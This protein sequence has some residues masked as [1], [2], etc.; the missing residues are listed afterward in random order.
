MTQETVKCVYRLVKIKMVI[1]V[2]VTRDHGFLGRKSLRK[3]D[4]SNS[5]VDSFRVCVK[6]HHASYSRQGHCNFKNRQERSW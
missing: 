1:Q 3:S 5:K 6:E 4:P 2:R